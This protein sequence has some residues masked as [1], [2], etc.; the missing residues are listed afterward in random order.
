MNYFNAG[1]WLQPHYEKAHKGG[2]DA[3]SMSSNV[4]CVA[5]GV[6]GWISQG[7]D[8]AIYSKNLCKYIDAIVQ[9]SDD[10]IEDPKQILIEAVAENRHIGSCTCV[11]AA[12]DK[13]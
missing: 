1:V 11:I 13:H 4:L 6:G 7:I 10:Y 9:K 12:L 2:E 5:D 8:P 3:A